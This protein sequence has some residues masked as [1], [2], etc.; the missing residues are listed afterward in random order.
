MYLDSTV[1]VCFDMNQFCKSGVTGRGG[2]VAW[3]GGHG[4]SLG[5]EASS[6]SALQP[7]VRKNSPRQK[8]L[9]IVVDG[10]T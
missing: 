4:G 1:A 8:A 7:P 10:A 5:G 9:K 2:G 3:F 6:S